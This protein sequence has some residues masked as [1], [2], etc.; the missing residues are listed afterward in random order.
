MRVKVS[1][2]IAG[3]VHDEVVSAISYE[4]AKSTALARNPSGRVI[5][6]SSVI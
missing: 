5:K 3:K 1:L 6:V 2:Y 4:E